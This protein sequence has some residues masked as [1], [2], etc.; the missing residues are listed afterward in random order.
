MC[1]A[2]RQV[3]HQLWIHEGYT[4]PAFL[5]AASVTFPAAAVSTERLIL[6]VHFRM[7]AASAVSCQIHADVCML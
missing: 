4:S 7:R 1:P 5:A 3:L 2:K 6:Q